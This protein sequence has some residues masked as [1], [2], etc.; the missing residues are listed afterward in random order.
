MQRF[1]SLPRFAFNRVNVEYAPDESG[2][3]GLFDG[4]EL[5]YIGRATRNG[6]SIREC[7]LRHQNGEYGECT[8]RATGYTW[9]ITGRPREREAELLA[10]FRRVERRD[11]RCQQE[12][13]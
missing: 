3:F 13:A 10:A 2:I 6:H 7:L 8:M 11:P 1:L 9:E 12:A 4:D 5:I